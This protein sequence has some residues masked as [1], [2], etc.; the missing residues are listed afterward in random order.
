MT[1]GTKLPSESLIGEQRGRTRDS[2]GE[3][4]YR[5]DA[6]GDS[7]CG[8]IT[9]YFSCTQH[10]ICFGAQDYM[11]TFKVYIA[12]CLLPFCAIAQKAGFQF[13][14][15]A[16]GLSNNRIWSIAQDTQGFIWVMADA[17]NRFDGQHFLNYTNR[18]D[19][20]FRKRIAGVEIYAVNEKLIFVQDKQI[21]EC[22]IISGQERAHSLASFV[23]ETAIFNGGEVV[24]TS[25]GDIIIPAF[26]KTKEQVFLIRYSD[27]ALYYINTLTD[28][29][30]DYNLMSAALY[31]NHSGDIFYIHE[32][33]DKLIK[34]NG[35]GERVQEIPLPKSRFMPIIKPGNN[36]S[37]LAFT[38]DKQF[39]VL[40]DGASEFRPL[41]QDVSLH[42]SYIRY[43][44]F[45]QT[46]KGDLWL[47]GGDRQ[48]LFYE[49]KTGRLYDFHQQLIQLIPNQL[50]LAE[51]YIDYSG[52]LWI[53]TL[54]GL[55]KI[56]PQKQWF[57]IYCTEEINVCKGHC[58]FRGF[59]E[60]ENG[61]IYASF[62]SNIFKVYPYQKTVS[63]PVL[64]E[65]HT[66]FD[67]HYETGKLLLND[68]SVFDLNTGEKNNPYAS[69][70]A[71]NDLGIYT[72]DQKGKIWWAHSKALYTLNRTLPA[73]KW[74]KVFEHQGK[75]E[76]L[77]RDIK[78]SQQ[79]VWI[80]ASN[81]LKCYDI[82]NNELQEF[83]NS[84][85]KEKI[86][87]RYIHPDNNNTVWIATDYGL[88]QFDYISG[89]SQRYT[90]K[91]GLPNNYVIS[92]LPEGDSCLWLGT[93]FGLSRF[94]KRNKTFL[95]FYAEDGLAHNE[96]NRRSAYQSKDGQLFFGGIRGIT[97]F[98]PHNVMQHYWEDRSLG[99]L[100]LTAFSKSDA[101]Q[102]TNL[103]TTFI[104]ENT[105][106]DILYANKTFQ[107]EY[108]LN[109]YRNTDK[110][111]Y[112]YQLEGYDDV[113]SAPSLSNRTSFNSLPSGKYLFRVKALTAR[114]QWHPQE[115]SIPVT[116]HPPWW[117]SS[118]AYLIYF[119]LAICLV[120]IT[121]VLIKRR[122]Q[123]RNQLQSEQQEAQRLKELDH[124]KSRLYTNLTHEFRTPL[125]VILGI[126]EELA[127]GSWQEMVSNAEK[128]RLK[129]SLGLVQRNGRS[130]LRL[131]NQLLDLSK[132][133]N[134][135][136]TLNIE[137]G[138]IV[139]YLRYITQSFQTF[140]NSANLSLQFFTTLE[141]L[142]M[143]F[144]PQQIQHIMTNLLSNAVKF[145]PSGGEIHVRLSKEE[146]T[147]KIEV[148]DNGI[149]IAEK[150]LPHI[151]DR[152]YQA[153][154]TATQSGS[155]TGIGLAHTQELAKLMGGNISVKS[156]LGKGTRFVV[157]LPVEEKGERPAVESGQ[158]AVGS[159]QLSRPY[160]SSHTQPTTNNQ[161]PATDFPSLLIIED[162]ADVVFYLKSCLAD[163]Y[164]LDIAY[165]GRI[166]IE[167]ALEHIPD[168]IIS[169]VMMP[170]KDGYEVCNTLKN[171]ERTSHI[172]IILL[173]AK[174]DNAS[175]IVGLK[176][177]ADVYLSKPFHKQ[178]LLVRLEMLIERQKR[179]IAYFFKI[180]TSDTTTQS[181]E[182]L[183]E[184]AIAVENIFIQKVQKIVAEN[185][186]DEHFALPQLCE[187][188]SMSRSQLYRKIKA[189]TG[190]SPSAF[191]RTYRLQ[192]AK[193]LLETED[194]TVS[195]VAW[196]VGF[197]D[198]AHFS[199]AFQ[200]KFGFW[201]SEKSK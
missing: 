92:I 90:V 30:A 95:N 163:K 85:F 38:Q 82:Q 173:T 53:R 137:Q 146:N 55:L 196:K 166:G 19:S 62:Y 167:K 193:L 13:Y 145:T 185:Y 126:A 148:K 28:I 24:Q 106:V 128:Q 46:P 16:D 187:A 2:E 61:N 83:E 200:E 162:N 68:G 73:P 99:H 22:N 81:T 108:A 122:W 182:V 23:P 70:Q 89:Y 47:S 199:K 42:K 98:Y 142:I 189:L 117:H 144:D 78:H 164:Q 116:V 201:P 74:Q 1:S 155:G 50:T 107:F 194:L 103:A 75:H 52:V 152:F 143:T 67:L 51:I 151:F 33:A 32:D 186:T 60:D 3:L 118:W 10:K 31:S 72:S 49:A 15:T 79:K 93:N 172:P 63:G 159:D 149:G 8:F 136:F 76:D 111:Q 124:F 100:A 119:L 154:N 105:H 84:I 45:I 94:H 86:Q 64:P 123:L 147:L 44:D 26:D 171:D 77:I 114:G 35:K 188:V 112:S 43:I 176:R 127:E 121:Y 48:L 5:E 104:K 138:D 195:E 180:F 27:K 170:E 183:K 125:T 168:L 191:I 102:N 39:Y 36:N 157:S 18:T 17:L 165:N 120:Y 169:D 115:L 37:I 198:R 161:Q 174:A 101:Q 190:I 140:T 71:S 133:E 192:Q 9:R 197:K 54:M 40:N 57:D 34:I 14:T 132:L 134:N 6:A 58:S 179:L 80:A 156:T 87:I 184:E 178:E 91:D 21:I 97:A 66:P 177:G 139:S 65:R 131:I 129:E 88:L 150:D 12:L 41:Y 69:K 96:F 29:L 160:I 141:N 11:T 113:W 175:K 4:L 7:G 130:L 110:T 153:D 109:D 59:T 25:S 135:A 56:Q 181:V 20:I 158:W